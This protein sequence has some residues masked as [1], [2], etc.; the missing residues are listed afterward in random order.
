M[1]AI[2]SSLSAT[3]WTLIAPRLA[4]LALR[5][6]AIRWMAFKSASPRLFLAEAIRLGDWATKLS[7]ILSKK[8]LPPILY[9][10]TRAVFSIG[11]ADIIPVLSGTA[12][13]FGTILTYS[14]L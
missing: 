1:L 6:W 11:L 4:A 2:S 9:R 3:S 14:R 8:S 12:D 13:W 10:L 7:I 5:E